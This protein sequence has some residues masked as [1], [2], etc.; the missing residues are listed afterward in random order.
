M[1]STPLIRRALVLMLGCAP[2][3]C[4]GVA[5]PA[6]AAIGR[7][8][9]PAS[10]SAA[11]SPG[12]IRPLTASKCSGKV[13]LDVVGTGLNVSDWTTSATLPSTMC[14]TPHYLE[15]GVVIA[16]GSSQCGSSGEILGSGWTDPGNFPNGTVLCNTW[17]GVSG[18]PCA[19]I[20]G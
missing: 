13:C 1:R 19:T 16:S 17:S 11:V 8:G 6:Q 3:V 7:A 20:I 10:V 5:N 18:E 15:N 2:I 9:A 12:A 14:T 4:L